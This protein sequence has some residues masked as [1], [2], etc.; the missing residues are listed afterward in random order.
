MFLTTDKVELIKTCHSCPEQYDA[1]FKGKQIGYLRL[2]HGEF[3]V[4]YPDCGDETILYSQ[5]PQGD[6]C[7][8]DD[9]REN[10]LMKAREAIVKKFNEMEG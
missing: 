7:F 2:R 1:F 4:D 6:G 10:F 9:E 8:E 5:E 3:R